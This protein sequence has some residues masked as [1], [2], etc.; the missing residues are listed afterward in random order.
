MHQYFKQLQ[1]WAAI[2]EDGD[3]EEAGK[4][5]NHLINNTNILVTSSITV[6]KTLLLDYYH[7]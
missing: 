4:M 1:Q 5:F 3:V 2:K 6:Y 7:L